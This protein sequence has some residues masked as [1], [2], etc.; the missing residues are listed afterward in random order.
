M[1]CFSHGKTSKKFCILYIL[2]ILFIFLNIFEKLNR[3]KTKTIIITI[4]VIIKAVISVCVCVDVSTVEQ[5]CVTD[6]N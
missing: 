1:L 6:K 3:C 2:Y 4:T 5:H